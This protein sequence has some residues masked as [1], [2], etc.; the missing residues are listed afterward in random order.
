MYP[1]VKL[2]LDPL[3]YG[4][5]ARKKGDTESYLGI[6]TNMAVSLIRGK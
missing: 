5:R 6:T 4:H 2:S 3:D 1:G